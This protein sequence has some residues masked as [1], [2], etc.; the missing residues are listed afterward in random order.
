MEVKWRGPPGES[1]LCEIELSRPLNLVE[2]AA[3]MHMILAWYDEG[4]AGCFGGGA[5]HFIADVVYAL[6][7]GSPSVEWWMD[8][9]RADV[10]PAIDDLVVRLSSLP[11]VDRLVVG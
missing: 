7:D 9:G 10:V 3:V 11:F 6:D 4:A 1:L 5:F 2:Q 8:S